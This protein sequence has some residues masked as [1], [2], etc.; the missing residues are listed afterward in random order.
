[1]ALIGV[2]T[3]RVLLAAGL[4]GATSGAVYVSTDPGARREARFWGLL[5]PLLAKYFWVFKF[6]K[7][8]DKAEKFTALHDMYAEPVYQ[9]FVDLGGLYVKLGQAMSVRPDVVPWQYCEQLKKLQSDVPGRSFEEIREI[10]EHELGAPLTEHYATFDETHVGAASVGQAHRATLRSGEEVVVKVQYPDVSWKFVVDLRCMG[11]VLDFIL[12]CDA[13]DGIDEFPVYYTELRDQS[14]LELDY[15]LERANL[16][17]IGASIRDI[18]KRDIAVPQSIPALCTDKLLTMTYLPGPKLEHEIL[19]R[20]ASLGIN[21]NGKLDDLIRG[22]AHKVHKAD[23]ANGVGAESELASQNLM[24][25]VSVE[26]DAILKMDPAA[27]TEPSPPVVPRTGVWGQV[28]S[29][30]A[31]TIGP[32]ILF[33]LARTWQWAYDGTVWAVLGCAQR[34]A[35]LGLSWHNLDAWA[36]RQTLAMRTQA[37]QRDTRQWLDTLLDV[38]G[39]EIFCTQLFNADPHPGNIILMPDNRLGLIDYGQCKR[40]RDPRVRRQVARLVVAVADNGT[41]EEI[42]EAFRAAGFLTKNDSTFFAAAFARLLFGHITADMLDV[43][44]HRKL[45]RADRVTY[46]PAEM[47]MVYRVAGLLRGLGLALQQDLSVGTAWAKYART[48]LDTEDTCGGDL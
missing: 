43:R 37:N 8:E 29:R 19:R 27:A 44:W 48:L 15:N 24:D 4:T 5:A 46:F 23:P 36:E 3:R 6:V 2:I 40:I 1:M 42:A 18:F 38:H 26:E 32:R 47:I 9:L 31:S 28:L 16:E 45:H 33:S 34:L 20:M 14:M 7:D 10:V 30:L 21:V 41:D 13:I 22:T 25:M 12:W 11:D 35:A 39:Y 17:E